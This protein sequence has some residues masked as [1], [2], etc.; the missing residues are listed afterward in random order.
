MKLIN[1]IKDLIHD[2]YFFFV[3]KIVCRKEPYTYQFTRAMIHHG[4]FFWIGFYILTGGMFYILFYAVIWLKV[5]SVLG[6]FLMAW[7]TDHLIDHARFNNDKY[8]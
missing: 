6:L 8:I 4:V 2:A 1:K 7:L 5:I 3:Y